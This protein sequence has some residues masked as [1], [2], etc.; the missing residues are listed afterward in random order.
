ADVSFSPS[1]KRIDRRDR[2]RSAMITGELHEGVDRAAIMKSFK[3][4]FAPEWKRNHLNVSLAERGDQE[5][6]ADFMKEFISLYVIALVAMYMLIAIGFG[7]YWQPILIMTAIPF[8]FMGAAFGHFIFG[9]NFAL[10]SFFGVG[11]A[12]GVV[13]NDNLVLIDTVNR[14]R[15]EGEGA[16]SALVKA[17]V[18]RF[19]PILLTSLT[20][21]LGLLPLMFSRAT[22]AQFLM[23]TVVA[24]AW[25]TFFALF[26]TLFFVPSLYVIGVDIARFYRWAWTGKEQAEFGEGASKESDFATP[27][28][29]TAHGQPG[30]PNIYRPAE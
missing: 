23:P 26:V 17:G 21:F 10:F 3:E 8:G 30:E 6:Q 25:G 2:K 1:Y 4:E 19:R 27:T 15:A 22:D 20:T 12:A 14:L 29:S 16:L 11:A 18:S 13:V 28:D 5:E 7:S 24:L 9:L